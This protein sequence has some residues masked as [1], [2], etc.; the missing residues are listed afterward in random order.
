MS[1]HLHTMQLSFHRTALKDCLDLLAFINLFDKKI[2]HL[3]K[4][5]SSPDVTLLSNCNIISLL[6]LYL[7]ISAS[8]ALEV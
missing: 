8:L 5:V 6:I 2:L 7:I 3:S 1:A 4:G